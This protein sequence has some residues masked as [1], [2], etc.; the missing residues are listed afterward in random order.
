[1]TPAADGSVTLGEVS[2]KLAAVSIT[3]REC[4]A[5]ALADAP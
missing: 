3:Y 4:R 1:M 5:A 2:D